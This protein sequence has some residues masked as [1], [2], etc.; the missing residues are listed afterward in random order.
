MLPQN[1][2]QKV[3]KAAEIAKCLNDAADNVTSAQVGDYLLGNRNV[4]GSVAPLL[5][6]RRMRI[7]QGCE[8]RSREPGT[9]S[10]ICIEYWGSSRP[11]VVGQWF[12]ESYSLEIDHGE[13]IT[14]L[15]FWIHL[16]DKDSG[17]SG[18]VVGLDI[19][20][21]SSKS[22]SVG[23][24]FSDGLLQITYEH[25]RLEQL[26]GSPSS[27]S[28]SWALYR[29]ANAGWITAGTLMDFQHEQRSPSSNYLNPHY[30]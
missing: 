30:P 16:Q 7:S 18:Q 22:L 2:A 4:L 20:T 15:S 3:E 24:R 26:V 10:G 5:E 12:E 25:T 8:G 1:T 6:I 23:D 13:M 29:L 21:S 14:G 19:S 27:S 11:K 17:N 28:S 9:I